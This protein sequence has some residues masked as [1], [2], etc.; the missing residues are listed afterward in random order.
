MQFPFL[1][2]PGRRPAEERQLFR[3]F[4]DGSFQECREE[5]YDDDGGYFKGTNTLS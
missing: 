4:E 1:S 5:Y 2:L 3:E